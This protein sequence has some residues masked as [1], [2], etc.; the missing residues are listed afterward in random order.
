MFRLTC[1]ELDNGEFAVYINHH[2]LGSED[3]RGERLSLGE[4]L[5]QLSRLP[6]VELQTLLEPLPEYDD[7]CWNDIADRVL[8]PL[9]ACRD[10]VTVAGLIARLKQYPPDALCMGTFWLEDDFLSL[11]GSLSE[12]EIAEAMRICYHSH[13]A[14]IGFNW[15]TLQFA[16]DHVKGR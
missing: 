12:E 5:E 14:G 13:D 11:D 3:A 9:P 10:D 1:I 8:P 6:G 16:I 15:D 4:V 7:W 2:Y